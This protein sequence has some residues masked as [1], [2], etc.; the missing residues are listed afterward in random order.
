[1]KLVPTIVLSFCIISMSATYSM[2]QNQGQRRVNGVPIDVAPPPPPIVNTGPLIDLRE[3]MRRFVQSISAYAKSL[4]P[5]FI[6]LAN[7]GTDLLVKRDTI[8]ETKVSPA[9]AYMRALDGIVQEGMF[10]D[11]A[12]GERPFGAPSIGDR[13]KLLLDRAAFAKKNGLKVFA[14]DFGTKNA[15]VDAA[16]KVAR[17]NNYVS[18]MTDAPTID[19]H[20][21]PKYPSRPFDENP[22]NILSLNMVKNFAVIRNSAPFGRPD[23]FA[24]KMHD[25]NYDML[26]VEVFHGRRALSR[27][28]VETLK[29]K[30]I[31]AKRLVLAYMDIG[32]AA[33]YYYYWQP[34]WREGSPHWISAPQRNDPDRYN[35]KFW[36]SAWKQIF[37][38]DTNS[39]IYGLITQGFDGVIIDGLEAYKM[40]ESNNDGDDEG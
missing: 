34:D 31:G 16:Y 25:T 12:R 28:A 21:I 18:F 13:Q 2:A 1:M 27:R 5:N 14:I 26:A 22:S 6:V 3:E 20:R 37:V 19:T 33:S 30:K 35:V 29:Y 40:L 11:V 24:L 15:A 23:Q 9:R 32:S 10:Y 8:I 39:Y 36:Q 38:G 7:G 4:R 17:K